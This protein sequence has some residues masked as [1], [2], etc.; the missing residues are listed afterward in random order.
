MTCHSLDGTEQVGP[1][2]QGLFG[3]SRDLEDGGS[4]EADE[5]YLRES[6]LEPNAQ[7]VAGYQPIMPASYGSLSEQQLNA[8]IAFIKEQ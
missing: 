7:I 8:L 3:S 5:N 2:F 1:T 4:V 6:I